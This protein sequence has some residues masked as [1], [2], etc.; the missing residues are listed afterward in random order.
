MKSYAVLLD[1]AQELGCITLAFG[2]G[3][4]FKALLAD[5]TDHNALIF[6]LLERKDKPDPRSET[7]FVVINAANN[8]YKAWGATCATPSTS[9]QKKPAPEGWV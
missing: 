4:D 6:A 1:Q 9:G 5:N 2:I 3:A 8:V 7:P